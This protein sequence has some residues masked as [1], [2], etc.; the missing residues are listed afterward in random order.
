MV[1][2]I[3][4]SLRYTGRRRRGGTLKAPTPSHRHDQHPLPAGH[5]STWSLPRHDHNTDM[6]LPPD[7][8]TPTQ[9]ATERPRWVIRQTPRKAHLHELVQ[10]THPP[11]NPPNPTRR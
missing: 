1:H 7:P 9:P 10:E 11:T 4:N 5:Q 8:V 3:W 6:P 2:L